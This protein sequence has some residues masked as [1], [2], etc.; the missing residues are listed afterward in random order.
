[1]RTVRLVRCQGCPGV[2]IVRVL[3]LIPWPA[4][5][6]WSY[7]R[8]VQVSGSS[9]VRT[10]RY[11]GCPG[12]RIVRDVRLVGGVRIVRCLWYADCAV[13]GVSG[14]SVVRTVQCPD[15]PVLELSGIRTVWCPG[16]SGVRIV[17]GFR[18][19]QCP[20]CPVS[21]LSSGYR[22]RMR[23]RWAPYFHS[24]YCK[25]HYS[26]FFRPIFAPLL[27][28]TKHDRSAQLGRRINRNVF[29]YAFLS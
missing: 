1:M 21:R 26:L 22:I 17:R 7:V 15:C 4:C 27:F 23:I 11:P 9:V 18:R 8:G 19:I 5:P 16:R 24:S 29:H 14:F 20:D 13:F 6:G 2:R 12:V 10:V 25:S 28:Y 3:R